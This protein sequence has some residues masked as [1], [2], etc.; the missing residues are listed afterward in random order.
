MGIYTYKDCLNGVLPKEND[1]IYLHGLKYQLSGYNLFLYNLEG[2]NSDIFK[3]IGYDDPN[4]FFEDVLGKGNFREVDSKYHSPYCLNPENARKIL[5]AIWET[6]VYKVGDIVKI[7]EHLEEGYKF[8]VYCNPGMVQYAGMRAKVVSYKMFPTRNMKEH[9][10]GHNIHYTLDLMY[11]TPDCDMHWSWTEDML[12][13][14]MQLD[15]HDDV[16]ET[17]KEMQY[18]HDVIATPK[19]DKNSHDSVNTHLYTSIQLPKQSKLKITL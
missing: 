13:R 16:E 7:T 19:V 17:K 1:E 4:K 14:C 9:E 12:E 3:L 8:A 11:P 6:P 2:Y 5:Q 15:Y 10:K 18:F